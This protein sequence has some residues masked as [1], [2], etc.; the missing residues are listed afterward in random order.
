MDICNNRDRF[1]CI[2]VFIIIGLSKVN[3]SPYNPDW[4]ESRPTLWGTSDIANKARYEA[5][6]PFV[7]I[8]VKSW[9][10]LC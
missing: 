1:C 8:Y 6:G 3:A 2:R 4:G 5:E 10:D 9:M 7:C